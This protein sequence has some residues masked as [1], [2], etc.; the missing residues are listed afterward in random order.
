[1]SARAPYGA[2][3]AVS[4]ILGLKILIADTVPAISSGGELPRP[5]RAA[6]AGCF[7]RCL[8]PQAVRWPH[9]SFMRAGDVVRAEAERFGTEAVLAA[10]GRYADGRLRPGRDSEEMIRFLTGLDQALDVARAGID[11]G[12]Y[13]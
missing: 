13:L 6:L 5:R 8:G 7:R 2:I 10:A 11:I 4:D 3:R 12:R 9:P 1:V